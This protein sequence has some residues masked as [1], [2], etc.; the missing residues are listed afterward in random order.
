MLNRRIFCLSESCRYVLLQMLKFSIYY[1][2]YIRSP[3]Y[4][5]YTRNLTRAEP[6]LGAECVG[7][8]GRGVEHAL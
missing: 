4:S 6:V 3:I 8:G 1:F 7:P 2:K 5:Q